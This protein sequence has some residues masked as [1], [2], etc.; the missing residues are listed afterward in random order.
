MT[1]AY[2][3]MHLSKGVLSFRKTKTFEKWQG[4]RSFVELVFIGDI[5]ES[6]IFDL[7]G[8]LRV[9]TPSH[10]KWMKEF[11]TTEICLGSKALE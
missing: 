6:L 11:V 8:L 10:R 2:P 3:F 4:E 5:V 1:F 7:W 9:N